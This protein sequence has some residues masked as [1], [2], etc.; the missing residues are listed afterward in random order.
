MAAFHDVFLEL[1]EIMHVVAALASLENGLP[2]DP[3]R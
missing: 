2:V 1:N 3:R